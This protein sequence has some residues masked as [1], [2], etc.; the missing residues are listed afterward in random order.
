[1]SEIDELGVGELI[2]DPE[3]YDKFNPSEIGNDLGFYYDLANKVKGKVLEL[4]CGT[5]RLTI[6]L[7]EKGINISGVDYTESMLNEA[8]RKA[9]DKNLSIDFILGDMKNLIFPHREHK[10]FD[11]IFIPFNSLQNTY[12]IEDVSKVF[13]SVSKYLKKDGIF[14]FDIFNPSINLMVERSK[15]FQEIGRF[16]LKNGNETVIEE[17]MNYDTATQT[18]RVIWR[19]VINGRIHDQKLDMRCF[20]PLEMDLHV[21]YNH[22]DVIEKYGDFNK[23]KFSSE[24]MK[25][26]YICKKS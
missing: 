3:I 24:S 26:I 12:S 15:Q 17:K 18:N 8:K 23:G 25:Q 2:Y 22:F 4:C 1:M 9:A 10:E 5:G 21:K 14:A 20:Y 19:H 16:T 7:K 13:S 11:M 6:P